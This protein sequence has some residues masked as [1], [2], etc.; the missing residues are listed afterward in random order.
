MAL[1]AAQAIWF[2]PFVAPICL[3]AAWSDLRFMKIRNKSVAAL[4]LVFFVVGLLAVPLAEYPW[5]VLQIVVVLA[6]GFLANMV[7]LL[8]AGD[9]K[10]AAGMAPFIPREDAGLFFMLLAIVMLA[11]LATHRL[12][13]ALPAFR[14]LTPGWKSWEV[15]DF[16]MGLALGGSLFFYLLLGLVAGS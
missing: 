14:R 13:R 2:L 6:V 10:F 8:G 7:G 4:L 11:A 3:W 12:F 9:A 1:T 15:R 16:P 5:R